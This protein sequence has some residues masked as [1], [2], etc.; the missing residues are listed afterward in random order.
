[1]QLI[2]LPQT[3]IELEADYL[4]LQQLQAGRYAHQIKRF[5]DTMQKFVDGDLEGYEDAQDYMQTILSSYRESIGQNL[6]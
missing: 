2:P 6:E 1:M 4:K 5:V 3:V